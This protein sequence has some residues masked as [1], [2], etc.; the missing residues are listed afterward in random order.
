MSDN[1]RAFA[2]SFSTSVSKTSSDSTGP[3]RL[4]RSII[5]SLILGWSSNGLRHGRRWRLL[6]G[7][8]WGITAGCPTPYV[9]VALTTCLEASVQHPRGYHRAM[10]QMHNNLSVAVGA[11]KE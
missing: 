10:S 4:D 7:A 5:G 3:S 6:D 11:A 2:Y 8:F 1:R 9:E